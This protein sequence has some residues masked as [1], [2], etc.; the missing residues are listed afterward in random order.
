MLPGGSGPRGKRSVFWS[1][2]TKQL[3]LNRPVLS[4]Y[5]S[6]SHQRGRLPG[7]PWPPPQSYYGSIINPHRCSSSGEYVKGEDLCIV[8]NRVG[9]NVSGKINWCQKSN[10]IP[11]WIVIV[12]VGCLSTGFFA[13]GLSPRAP[14]QMHHGNSSCCIKRYSNMSD[15]DMKSDNIL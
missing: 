11:F 7:P 9:S 1:T 6:A 13:T 5:Y 3:H 4:H 8:D 14:C 10:C 2:A 15:K 12:T